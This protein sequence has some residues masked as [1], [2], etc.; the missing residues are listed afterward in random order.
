MQYILLCLSCTVDRVGRFFYFFLILCICWLFE[1]PQGT[2]WESTIIFFSPIFNNL[3][4][5]KI[6]IDPPYCRRAGRPGGWVCPAGGGGFSKR[7][8]LR[9][10]SPWGQ[11]WQQQEKE[12]SVPSAH[13][14]KRVS[15]LFFLKCANVVSVSK[16]IMCPPVRCCHFIGFVFS[17]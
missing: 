1:V 17:T 14:I 16:N 9:G 7:P 2:T 12:S 11:R 8:H 10:R 5:L 4:M 15:I 13:H 3:Q 6:K